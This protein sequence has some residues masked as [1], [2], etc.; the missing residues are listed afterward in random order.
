[1][2]KLILILFFVLSSSKNFSQASRINQPFDDINADSILKKNH[3]TKEIVYRYDYEE[4]NKDSELVAVKFFNEYGLCK[5]ADYIDKDKKIYS[6]TNFQYDEDRLMKREDILDGLLKGSVTT[7]DYNENGNVLRERT[8]TI[9]S[10]IVLNA[11][12]SMQYNDLNQLIKMQVKNSRYSMYYLYS[13]YSNGKLQEQKQYDDH[14]TLLNDKM[15]SYDSLT[16]TDTGY[17]FTYEKKISYIDFYNQDKQL[18]KVFSFNNANFHSTRYFQ[19]MDNKLLFFEKI[20][21][22]SGAKFYFKFFY[23]Y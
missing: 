17:Y 20:Q 3:I 22:L 11:E 13:Y 2:R 21:A 16:N 10:P 7:F 1:M 23:S 14:N 5:E 15:Y 18:I 8:Y 19:Y 9:D 4:K 12:S 6:S